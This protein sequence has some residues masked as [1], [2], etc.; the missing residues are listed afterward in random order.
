MTSLK[1][2]SLYHQLW[3]LGGFGVTRR[4]LGP[5]TL[6]RG[7][8][9]SFLKL[10]TKIPD[11]I[12]L[13]KLGSV[14]NFSPG[15]LREATRSSTAPV[16]ESPWSWSLWSCLCFD[17]LPQFFKTTTL[18][19]HILLSL[20]T[21]SKLWKAEIRKLFVEIVFWCRWTTAASTFRSCA[22]KWREVWIP[23][24]NVPINPI[25]W[26]ICQLLWCQSSSRIHKPHAARS[27]Y[28]PFFQMLVAKHSISFNIRNCPVYWV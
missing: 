18:L 5:K 1:L 22:P 8:Q 13:P 20:R 26:H 10:L 14:C 4:D 6:P 25:N 15:R 24:R 21:L 27:H 17:K 23:K 16:R 3:P 2:Q 7:W 9:M 19:F 28:Q 12:F 11:L